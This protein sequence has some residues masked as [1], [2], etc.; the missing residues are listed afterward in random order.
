[1]LIRSRAGTDALRSRL[2]S[3]RLVQFVAVIGQDISEP[4]PALL[5]QG[6]GGPK[7]RLH[8][9]D[10]HVDAAVVLADVEVEVFVVHVH[11]VA[12]GQVVFISVFVLKN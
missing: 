12:L 2:A 8:L 10:A 1:M 11:L 7:V 6:D 5:R 9:A 4:R 3:L